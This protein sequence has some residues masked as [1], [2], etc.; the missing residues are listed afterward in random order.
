MYLIHMPSFL[1]CI[2]ITLLLVSLL[3]FVISSLP[4]VSFTLSAFC[5][6]AFIACS[7]LVVVVECL[8]MKNKK[9]NNKKRRSRYGHGW[10]QSG[11]KVSWRKVKTTTKPDKYYYVVIK[12]REPG[13]YRKWFD[14]QTQVKGFRGT[15]FLAHER[16]VDVV[17]Y[18]HTTHYRK[19]ILDIDKKNAWIILMTEAN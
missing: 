10:S 6:I 4:F 18:F 1:V 7:C 13:I 15:S 8:T 2:C 14:V 12:D 11:T 3:I 16:E 17:N 5:S 19:Y 9:I